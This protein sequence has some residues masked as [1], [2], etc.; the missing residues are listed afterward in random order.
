[1]G[2]TA[3]P[4][5]FYNI[6][7]SFDQ[8]FAT[9][10]TAAGLPAWMPSAV[11]NYDFPQKALTFPS[12]SVTHLGTEPREVAQGRNLDAGWKGVEQIGLADIRAWVSVRNA[13]GAQGRNLRQMRDMVARVF[14]T[15][16]AIPIL[17]VYGS[18]AAPT[19]NGTIIRCKPVREVG[20]GPDPN[21]DIT[22]VRLLVEY[23]YLERATAG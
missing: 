7:G 6:A 19:G 16:A 8:F 10:L 17:D 13:S 23:R 5:A 18:T 20:V 9:Q 15:G 3:H 21:P 4:G 22:A 11:V 2:F 1:M 12:F 14:A